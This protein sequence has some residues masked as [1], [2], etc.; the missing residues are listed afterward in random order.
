MYQN[1]LT[2]EEKRQVWLAASCDERD[3]PMQIN[4]Q[5][6]PYFSQYDLVAHGGRIEVHD[7]W[8]D[9]SLENMWS[10]IASANGLLKLK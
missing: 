2:N 1:K 10:K 4:A 5:H 7:F 9:I 8:K 3:W 6:H